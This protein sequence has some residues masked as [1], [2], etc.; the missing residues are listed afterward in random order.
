MAN[1]IIGLLVVVIAIL[2]IINVITK[3]KSCCSGCSQD[4]SKCDMNIKDKD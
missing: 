4:C 3:E 2:A 1:I